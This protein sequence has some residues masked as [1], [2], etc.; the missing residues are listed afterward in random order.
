MM[1]EV[2]FMAEFNFTEANPS[3]NGVEAFFT[4]RRTVQKPLSDRL[5]L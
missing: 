2:T 4:T 5:A 3:D 1:S